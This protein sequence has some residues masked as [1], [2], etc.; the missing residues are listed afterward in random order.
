MRQVIILGG[1]AKARCF[2]YQLASSAE[3]WGINFQ[4]REWVPRF[5][6]MFNIHRYE[7][8][9]KYGYPCY[10]DAKWAR[11][12]PD[13]RI[14]IADPW[15]DKRIAHAE[16]FPANGLR[17]KYPRGDYHCNSLD[18]LIAYALYEGFEV[19]HLHG[20]RIEREGAAEQLSAARCAEYWIGFAEGR[21]MKVVAAEDSAI[22]GVYHLVLSNRVYG[23]DDCPYY[24]DRRPEGKDPPYR[25]D[26]Y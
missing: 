26:D 7:L 23:Y 12:H 25:Y 1:G 15:P 8:L 21:G 10:A 9:K 6:R 2:D 19:V 14:F 22:C 18:W 13:V 11:D 4:D 17:A 16:I 5:D 20:F 3:V 24:E